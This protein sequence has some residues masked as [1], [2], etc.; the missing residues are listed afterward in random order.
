VTAILALLVLTLAW[1][2]YSHYAAAR[3]KQPRRDMIA[4]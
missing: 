4:E 1:S 2:G 3:R